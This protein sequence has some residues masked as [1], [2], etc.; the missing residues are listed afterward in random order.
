MSFEQIVDGRTHARTDVPTFGH[1]LG[2]SK[3][4]LLGQLIGYFYQYLLGS[5][6]IY[7]VFF[8]SVWICWLAVLTNGPLL[9]IIVAK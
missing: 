9:G 2:M 8:V 3:N 4:H 5:P 1:L 6:Y 7:W